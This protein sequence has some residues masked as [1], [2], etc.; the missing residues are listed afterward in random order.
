MYGYCIVTLLTCTQLLPRLGRIA[1]S[2]SM[3]SW[4]RTSTFTNTPLSSYRTS[5]G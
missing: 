2:S 5:S 1:S 4:M 3:G